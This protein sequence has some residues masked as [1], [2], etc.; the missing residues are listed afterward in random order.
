M[1][2]IRPTRGAMKRPANA[3]RKEDARFHAPDPIPRP[4]RRRRRP[5][6]AGRDRAGRR[7]RHRPRHDSAAGRTP[8]GQPDP[9]RPDARRRARPAAAPPAPPGQGSRRASSRRADLVQRPPA[10]RDPAPARGAARPARDHRRR[11]G[12][13]GRRRRRRHPAARRDR[14]LRVGRRPACGRRRR[15]LPRQ[16]PVHVLELAG[17][18]RQRRPRCRAGGRAGPPRGDADGPLGRRQ[19]ARLRLMTGPTTPAPGP[20]ATATAVLRVPG[21]AGRGAG[22]RDTLRGVNPAELRAAFP[23]LDRLAYLNAGTC[24]PVPRAAVEAARAELESAAEAGR[25]S[26]YFERLRDLQARHRAAYAARV[27]ARPED[28]ALT[29]ST[30]DGVAR[31]VAALGLRRGDEIVT[32]DEEHPGVYGP[33]V[34]AR[35]RLGV[36]VRPV[37]L[38]DVADAIGPDTALVACSHVGW[39]SGAVAPPALAEVVNVPVLLDGA[40]GAGAV[41]VDVGAL[42]CAFYAAAGQKWLCGPIGTGLLYVAPEWR[43]RLPPA[44][45]GHVNL[46]DPHAGLDAVP[47]GDARAHDASALPPE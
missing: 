4:R 22:H 16:V 24:G 38:A 17:R 39:V 2:A 33:V 6:H 45:P 20:I 5:C 40:Q 32:S 27:G 7:A 34:A 8:R 23:V 13:G 30:T 19:L 11:R 25:W 46:G 3:R 43:E 42:R 9:A 47:H 14:R 37:A 36:R 18:R 12:P 35:E 21:T 41:P 44:G 31:V 10:R 15:R 28:V 1:T 26:P 29:T